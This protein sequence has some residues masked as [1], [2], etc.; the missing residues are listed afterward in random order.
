MVNG[1]PLPIDGEVTLGIEIAGK[2]INH[3]FLVITDLPVPIL[4]GMDIL[5]WS[6]TSN[7]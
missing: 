3:I 6:V 1:D 2:I 5:T 7:Y 4:I